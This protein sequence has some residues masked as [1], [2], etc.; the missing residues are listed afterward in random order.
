MRMQIV[1]AEQIFILS[2]IEFPHKQ[3]CADGLFC[4]NELE[5]EHEIAMVF[6]A[7]TNFLAFLEV[8]A[9]PSN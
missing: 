9:M 5:E 1:S 3:C 4:I 2:K 6:K 8:F 7:W